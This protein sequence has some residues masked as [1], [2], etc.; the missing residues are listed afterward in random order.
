MSAKRIGILA[1]LGASVAWAFEPIFAKLSYATADFL[2]TSTTR[3]IFVTLIALIY[4]LATN[5]GN[6]KVSRKQLP[7]LVYLAFAGTLFADL[8]YLFALTRVPVIN[9][10]L[11]GHMQPIFIV[12]IGFFYL[13]EDKLTRFDYA[14][15]IFMIIAG[16]LVTTRTLANLSMLKL[17]TIYDLF[18]LSA[19]VAWATTGV[20]T[21]K[22]LRSMNAGVVTFYR[23]LIASIVFVA[24][25][26]STSS[27]VVSNIY[28]ILIGIVVGGGYILY[29]EGL[30]RIK[31]AQSSAL[32]LSTPFFATLLSFFILGE[33][34]TGM[35]ILGIFLLFVGVCFLS[36]KE[37]EFK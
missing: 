15:I 25:L 33:T 4:A 30:K 9:V 34:V 20:V 35:Q 3:A 8:M 2:K 17:G 7:I 14:G 5:K 1:T 18:V 27:L 19:T 28:Q 29:Y 32:E 10:V 36:A 24:Y 23:F 12:F 26:L 11:I 13:K 31:A 6:L 37:E 21:R 22:Y 16:L